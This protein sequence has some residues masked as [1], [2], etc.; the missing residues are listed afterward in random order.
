MVV[1][2]NNFFLL[3]L[4]IVLFL[5]P[6]LAFLVQVC[7]A[8]FSHILNLFVTGDQWI[9]SSMLT[10]FSCTNTFSFVI[11]FFLGNKSLGSFSTPEVTGFRPL[12]AHIGQIVSFSLQ[13]FPHNTWYIRS[14][15]LLNLSLF[16]VVILATIDTWG[17]VTGAQ[18][19]CLF[20][21][22]VDSN[23]Y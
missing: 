21:L 3:F 1:G 17:W 14:R 20:Q 22:T 8:Q 2:K 12:F 23:D 6:V 16:V 15:N 9:Y 13:L 7:L 10:L 19:I 11:E 5:L 4:F 18:S